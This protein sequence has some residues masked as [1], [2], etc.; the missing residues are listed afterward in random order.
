[1]TS[2]IENQTSD[3]I[4]E[5]AEIEISE[6]K[7]EKYNAYVQKFLSLMKHPNLK[8]TEEILSKVTPNN[9]FDTY[10]STYFS[11][12][13]IFIE[14]PTNELSSD[15]YKAEAKY[16][17]LNYIKSLI[18]EDT[19]KKIKELIAEKQL[20][21]NFTKYVKNLNE[22]DFNNFIYEYVTLDRESN[23]KNNYPILKTN[24]FAIYFANYEYFSTYITI[25][26]FLDEIMSIYKIRI[27]ELKDI[28]NNIKKTYIDNTILK[29]IDDTILKISN[30]NKDEK[31]NEVEK[32]KNENEKQKILENLNLINDNLK[33]SEKKIGSLHYK[34]TVLFHKLTLNKNINSRY[35]DDD[36]KTLID[37]EL[38][39]KIDEQ[40]DTK[41][42]ENLQKYE[43]EMK[44]FNKNKE[45]KASARM[46]P[47]I[48][49]NYI[50]N[51]LKNA[52]SL[53]QGGKKKYS[54]RRVNKN[55]QK[56]K[57]KIKKTQRKK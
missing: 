27:Q 52:F 50:G 24:Y 1:M 8:N 38:F 42:K 30:L 19:T 23:Y 34:F 7:Q 33:T 22:I 18:L 43:E 12:E 10:F 57:K 16:Y 36:T 44:I 28:E 13:S 4:N 29:T 25:Q 37:K 26:Q 11:I 20:L 55:T 46:N 21:D 5:P 3:E 47:N 48:P 45:K 40:I 9:Y 6:F 39:A 2:V 35:D 17:I 51:K 14:T 53:K 41:K 15:I 54:R 31:Q 32:Q 56:A 49:I